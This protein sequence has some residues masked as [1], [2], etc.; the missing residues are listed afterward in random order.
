VH[1]NN[2]DSIGTDTEFIASV[3]PFM[4]KKTDQWNFKLGFQALVDRSSIL[5]FYPDVELGFT[6]V[7]SYLSF[8]ANL[9]GKMERNEPLKMVS[10][11]PYLVSDQ[12]PEFVS[13]GVLFKLP[14]TDHKI[15]VTSGLKGN[16]GVGGNWLVSATYSVIDDMLFYSNLVFPDTINPRAMGNYFLPIAEAVNLLNLHAEMNGQL[17]DK[18]SFRWIANS[19]TYSSMPTDLWNKPNWD[20]QFGLKYNLR[21]KIIAG[22]EFTAIGKRKQV[23]NGDVLSSRA[24]YVSSTIDMPAHFNLNLSAEYRYSRI[25][26]F[27]TTINNIA[28][29]KYYEWAYYPSKRFMFMLGF[30]YSL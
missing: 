25:L 17:N 13:G 10:E 11:N 3:N 30:T 21:D 12:F 29:D 23:I 8:F 22:L 26:S 16:T 19:Y 27:W 2:S 15:V 5:H 9:S 1:Y 14:D 24:G 4:K 6:I 18:L 7:P 28:L 20:G